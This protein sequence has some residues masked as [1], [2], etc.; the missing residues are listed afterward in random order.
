MWTQGTN[1]W[2]VGPGS[3]T[4]LAN[5]RQGCEGRTNENDLKG[6][7]AQ[8]ATLFTLN[9][10]WMGGSWVIVVYEGNILSLAS[11]RSK[12]GSRSGRT[13]QWPAQ[14]DPALVGRYWAT[15]SSYLTPRAR[16][17]RM[18]P[19]SEKSDGDDDRG[20]NQSAL[21]TRG[22]I[23]DKRWPAQDTVH[24][25]YGTPKY[26]FHPSH[27]SHH[28]ETGWDTWCGIKHLLTSYAKSRVIK[29]IFAVRCRMMKSLMFHNQLYSWIM[30]SLRFRNKNTDCG[31][32]ECSV[33]SCHIPCW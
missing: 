7:P 28:D 15:L 16:H 29:T 8:N 19:R 17:Y 14:P 13:R 11:A 3:F 10:G 4:H 31:I 32:S 23:P 27:P 1:Q 12:I 9:A 22:D 26:V 30:K 20:R 21:M 18:L 24:P 6:N 2:T 5:N 25:W 33:W